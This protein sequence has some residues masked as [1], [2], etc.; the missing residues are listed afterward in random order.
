MTRH[1][2]FYIGIQ[3]DANFANYLPNIQSFTYF[4]FFAFFKQG[5]KTD[6]S[7]LNM[8]EYVLD[9]HPSQRR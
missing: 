9:A 4:L 8:E 5:L 2:T 1:I 6:S 7:P 3:I